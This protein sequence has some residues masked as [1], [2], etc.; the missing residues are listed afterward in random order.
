M[1]KQYNCLT[2]NGQQIYSSYSDT[3]KLKITETQDELS[4][5]SQII[6]DPK[7]IETFTLTKNTN[8]KIERITY[9]SPCVRNVNM[10]ASFIKNANE[11]LEGQINYISIN[12]Y[13]YHIEF[14][15]G[16]WTISYYNRKGQLIYTFTLDYNAPLTEDN[17]QPVIESVICEILTLNIKNKIYHFL[18][19]DNPADIINN[20]QKSIIQFLQSLL[21]AE[22]NQNGQHQIDDETKEYLSSFLTKLTKN[23]N[24]MRLLEHNGE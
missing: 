6:T 5:N 7:V 22:S 4:I 15:N 13:I 23:T 10:D 2:I 19:M 11:F 3:N 18:I 8:T 17:F 21:L 24:L 12:G 16:I 9:K 14:K 20:I 1:N